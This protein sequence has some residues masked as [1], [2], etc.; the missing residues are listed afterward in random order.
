MM[1]PTLFFACLASWSEALVVKAGSI[2]LSVHVHGFRTFTCRILG[3]WQTLLT[4]LEVCP[5]Y[6][7]KVEIKFMGSI[8]GKT[9]IEPKLYLLFSNL[10]HME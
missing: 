8:G 7:D 4:L 1:V 9:P 5:T 2:L 6:K 10:G 3:N